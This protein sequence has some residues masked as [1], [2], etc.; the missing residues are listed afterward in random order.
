MPAIQSITRTDRLAQLESNVREQAQKLA[1]VSQELRLIAEAV[2]N[3]RF[4]VG[5]IVGSDDIR[6]P[7]QGALGGFP[8]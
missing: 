5:C 4:P 7:A 1:A 8:R 6:P 2:H 3:D